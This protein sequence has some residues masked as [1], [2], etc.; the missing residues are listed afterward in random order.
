MNI[1]YLWFIKIFLEFDDKILTKLQLIW[2]NLKILI[3]T[4]AIYFFNERGGRCTKSMSST[5]GVSLWKFIRSTWLIFSKLLP[6]E[7]N[8]GS[9]WWCGD[10]TLKEAFPKFYCISK[11]R[12]S[13]IAEVMCFF[14]GGSIRMLSF[15]I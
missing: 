6:Y 9:M 2:V 14:W 5:C 15:V 10:C 8:F 11:A 12:E 3:H 4:I 7:W 13:S 1:L